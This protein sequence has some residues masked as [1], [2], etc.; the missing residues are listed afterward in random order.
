MGVLSHLA[1]SHRIVRWLAALLLVTGWGVPL[2]LPHYADDDAIC[3]VAR[4]TDHADPGRIGKLNASSPPD[5]CAVCHA[6]RTFRSVLRSAASA[7]VQLA[8]VG[9]VEPSFGAPRHALVFDRVPAR[10]PPASEFPTP[11]V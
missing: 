5:H 6:A 11:L 2:A 10:A 4:A 9:R 8:V 3:A 7:G 1:R